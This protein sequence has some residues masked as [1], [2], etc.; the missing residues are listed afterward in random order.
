MKIK[1]DKETDILYIKFN[2]LPVDESDMEKEGVILDYSV[3]GQLVGIEVLAAS[4]SSSKP[5]IVEYELA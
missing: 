2:D 4:K 3:D 5:N 1:Y